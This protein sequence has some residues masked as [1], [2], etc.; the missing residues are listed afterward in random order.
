VTPLV[1]RLRSLWRNVVRRRQ[2]DAELAE[3][4]RAY[5][6]EL[7]ERK[8]RAGLAP[9]T[10]RR[11]A[12]AEM[13][14]ISHVQEQVR[15]ER[16]G[17]RL[18]SWVL[19]LAYAARRM[20]ASPAFTAAAVLTIALGVGLNVGAFSLLNSVLFGALPVPAADEIVDVRETVDGLDGRNEKGMI[21]RRFTTAEYLAL[22]DGS[23]TLSGLLGYSVEWAVWLR[24]QPARQIS[25]RYVTCNYFDV[26]RQPPVVGRGL[27]ADDCRSGAAP[28]VVLGHRLWTTAFAGD[29]AVVG[30]TVT[31]NR[32]QVTVVG[33][34]AEDVY[35]PELERLDYF[36]PI[37]IQPLLRP[38]RQWLVSDSFGW[39]SLIG[40]RGAGNGLAEVRAELDVIAAQ[41]DLGQP[42][43][44]TRMSVEPA[45][46][47]ATVGP[48]V[49]GPLGSIGQWTGGLRSAATVI[50]VAPFG[51]IL[52]IACANVANL[53]LARAAARTHEIA[54]RLSLGASRSR[55]VQ[56]LLTE[57]VLVSLVGGA[58]GLALAFW[59]F[60]GLTALLLSP[61]SVVLPD[62]RLDGRLLA[63]A[64]GLSL[65]TGVLTG[66]APALRASGTRLHT[67][68]NSRASSGPPAA[69]RLQGVFIGAQVAVCMA[70]LVGA[71]LLLR[72]LYEANLAEPGFPAEQVTTLSADL[73]DFGYVD[74]RLVLFQRRLED[75]VRAL[76]GVEA[77]VY[78]PVTPWDRRSPY[79]SVAA[80][81][82]DGLVSQFAVADVESDYLTTLGIPIVRGRS[83][84]DADFVGEPAAVIVSEATASRVWPGQDP[85]GQTLDLAGRVSPDA[86]ETVAW[87]VVGVAAD[88]H[89]AF[90]PPPSRLIYRPA[91]PSPPHML[92]LL[93]RSRRPF[94]SLAPDIDAVLEGLDP[95]VTM[96]VA[97]LETNLGDYRYL[98][99]VVSGLAVSLGMLALA[100]ATVGIYGVV[101]HVVA[102]RRRE[103]GIRLAL[104][105]K[106]RSVMATIVRRT[107][108]PV[109]VG[110]VVGGLAA[111][112]V[113]SLLA[114]AVFGLRPVDPIAIGAAAFLVLG[115]AV[116]A[117][118][119]PARRGLR[120]DPIRTLQ[121]E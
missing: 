78:T 75:R 62:P 10:A 98:S 22:R 55:V 1:P 85:I 47:T 12:L 120:A 79:G 20:K 64:V 91:R 27:L 66:L 90:G 72:V 89:T 15:S 100:L 35:Q 74:D 52:L 6:D 107:L 119:V 103:I 111:A 65:A 58:L 26:L 71:G 31:L 44:S 51:F 116:M 24:G 96:R 87:R 57:S 92:S 23:E 60:E 38:D 41:I 93:V 114:S 40:R 84:D 88:A 28:V 49:G 32:A 13:G 36:A 56:Q 115:V 83:F 21:N 117:S 46:V 43:R 29:P 113:S 118:V 61:L 34:A 7:T 80:R 63:F 45:R 94:A 81:D 121:S 95:D 67:T 86:E 42:G 76:S 68:A 18:E 53:F 109:V 5:A 17:W 105:A 104:G 106:T 39:L 30:R 112:A 14:R 70:L 48:V 4:L 19:D 82:E 69:G 33:V 2:V 8:R 77:V 11:Q 54:T 99:L 50:I 110:A 59:S 9:A 73:R 37:T 97:P 25:G 16:V 108:R 101:A 102:H 3:E